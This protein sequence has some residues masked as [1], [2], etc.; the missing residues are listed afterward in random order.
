[1][2]PRGKFRGAINIKERAQCQNTVIL[3]TAIIIETAFVRLSSLSDLQIL[4]CAMDFPLL[5]VDGQ[6]SGAAL[7]LQLKNQFGL[8]SCI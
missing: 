5:V 6:H 4:Y 8:A 2:I 3:Y 7:M 1:M